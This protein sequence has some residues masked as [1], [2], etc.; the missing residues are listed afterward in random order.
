[1]SAHLDSGSGTWTWQFK[2]VDGVWR[3]IYGSSDF[4]TE[5]VYTATNMVN[6]FFGTDTNV[7]GDASSGSSPQWD[8]QIMSNPRNRD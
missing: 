8:W 5:Q 7:R 6:A 1:L 3:S 2:G 4:V